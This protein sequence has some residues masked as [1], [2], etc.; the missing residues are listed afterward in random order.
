[1]INKIILSVLV[2]IVAISLIVATKHTAFAQQTTTSTT[3]ILT[4][5]NSTYGIKIQYPSSWDEEQNGTKQDT[6]TDIITFYP[7]AVNSNASLDVTMDDISDEKGVSLSQYASDDIGD[8]KQSLKD[9]KLISSDIKNII[10]SGLPAYKSIYTYSDESTIFKDMEIGTIKGDKAYILTYEA[11]ANEYDRYL[12][13][14]NGLINSF[15][16]TK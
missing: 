14:V 10:L 4:Y 2:L 1:M 6:E 7:P 16:I 3:N 9:F 13:T 15:Q 11:G 12:P 5:K 8:L